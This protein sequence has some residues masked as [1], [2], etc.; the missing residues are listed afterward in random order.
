MNSFQST[1]I[2]ATFFN[3]TVSSGRFAFGGATANSGTG[4]DGASNL[5]A[6]KVALG[7]MREALQ[8]EGIQLNPNAQPRSAT[9]VATQVLQRVSRA[10]DGVSDDEARIALLEKAAEGIA[11]GIAEARQILEKAGVLNGSVA[12]TVDA[13]AEQL[14]AGLQELAANIVPV[15]PVK[16]EVVSAVDTATPA[17]QAPAS[18]TNSQASIGVGVLVQRSANISIETQDGDVITLDFNRSEAAAV[19]VEGQAGANGVSVSFSAVRVVSSDLNYSVQG[20][21]DEG[22]VEALDELLS[23]ISKVADT[24]FGGQIAAAFEKASNLE[25]DTEELSRYSIALQSTVVQTVVSRYQQVAELGNADAATT[26][27]I[28]ETPGA[29]SNSG[30][31]PVDTAMVTPSIVDA[32]TAV[33]NVAQVVD[34]ATK[35]RTIANPGTAVPDL[36]ETVAR[37]RGLDAQVNPAG[38]SFAEALGLLRDLIADLALPTSDS[39]TESE[40]EKHHGEHSKDRDD[41]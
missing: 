27:A 6:S 9:D 5:D 17:A 40:E 38:Q 26:G 20:E 23:K 29:H 41:E 37:A 15:A 32:A 36:I 11:Q 14:Q 16:R 4:A 13:I 19:A 34:F 31:A 21:L 2:N 8:G 25:L 35:Q 1:A 28:G 12:E 3:A 22:E 18:V 30:A 39:D 33:G 24:F 7:R 10:L